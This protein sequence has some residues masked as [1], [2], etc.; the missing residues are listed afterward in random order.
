[1]VL[2][3]EATANSPLMVMKEVTSLTRSGFT[4]GIASSLKK[5]F[6]SRSISGYTTDLAKTS[7]KRGSD[8]I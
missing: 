3:A 7:K 5:D 8:L 6:E 4:L 2:T 1:M